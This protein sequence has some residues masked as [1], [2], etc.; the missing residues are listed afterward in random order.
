MHWSLTGCRLGLI[1]NA[2]QPLRV[3]Y[4]RAL[5]RGGVKVNPTTGLDL[6]A[7]R[8]RRDTF[9]DGAE[10]VALVAAL[11]PTDRAAWALMLFA[12]LRLGEMRGLRWEHV[13]LDARELNVEQAYCNTAK[14]MI[15]PKSRAGTRTIPV[16]LELLRVLLEHRL[17]TGKRTGLV[18][19]SG[20]GVE[21]R[22]RL[23]HR[24]ERKWKAG[25][26]T[27]I[28]PHGVPLVCIVGDRVG[29]PVDEPS[30]VHG[31]RVNPDHERPLR[32]P[33]PRRARV[34]GGCD[35][36]LPRLVRCWRESGREQ[37][38]NRVAMLLGGRFSSAFQAVDGG[39]IPLARSSA[40]SSRKPAPQTRPEYGVVRIVADEH[41][42]G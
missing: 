11:D 31:P 8:G 19:T 1:R 40:Q 41:P 18:V 34:G 24:S 37:N 26:L 7:A 33:V 21:D 30:D 22:D 9:V 35:G 12:G 17:L 13:D 38:V 29:R 27:P 2:L 3:V 23:Q 15:P 36:S 4:R 28:S 5:R 25:G 20:G 6:P 39:S 42:S 32:P 10:A 16:M 14:Q